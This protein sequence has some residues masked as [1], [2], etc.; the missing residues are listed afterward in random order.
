MINIL[1]LYN[2]YYQT[3]VIKEHLK[4]LIENEEVAFGKIKSKLKKGQD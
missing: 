4:L 1:I 3:D 2:P